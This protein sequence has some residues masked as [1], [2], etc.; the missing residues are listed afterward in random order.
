MKH[1]FHRPFFFPAA[2]LAVA[3]SV[4][5]SGASHADVQLGTDPNNV[6]VTVNDDNGS[7]G[8]F[9]VINGTSAP[10]TTFS[11]SLNSTTIKAGSNNLTVST[12]GTS[13]SGNLSA[14]SISASNISASSLNTTG[15]ISASSL[16]T[17]GAVSANSVTTTGAVSASGFTTSGALN[18]GSVNSTGAISADSITANGAVNAASVNAATVNANAVNTTTVN[19][20][21]A[22]NAASF[23]TTGAVNAGSMNVTGS[24]ALYGATSVR[25]TFNVATGASS[26]SVQA[27]SAG[28][29]SGASSLS[30]DSANQTAS[31]TVTNDAGNTHGLTVGNAST[32]LSG[33]TSSTYMTLDDNGVS[34]ANGAGAPVRVSGVADGVAPNDAANVNQLNQVRNQVNAMGARIDSVSKHASA[35]IAGVTALANIPDVAQGKR[36]AV[37]AGVGYYGGQTALA[38]ALKGNINENLRVSA[39]AGF[40]GTGATVGSGASF[41]W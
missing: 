11:S 10:T 12:S 29:T 37:G 2:S 40:G 9:E 32:T 22:V 26:L 21:G 38:V 28:L 39:G 35:G 18:A 25:N 33:G 16:T 36:F 8:A 17:T 27:A 14:G 24:T 5:W 4:M 31:L 23:N 6:S 34:L 30:L 13:V 3:V 7:I 20:T 19:A 15:G 41:S 1:S